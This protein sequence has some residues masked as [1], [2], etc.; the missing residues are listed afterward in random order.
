[1]W[2]FDDPFEVDLVTES[3]TNVLF[4]RTVDTLCAGVSPTTLFFDQSGPGCQPDPGVGLGTG[5]N[6]CTV[7]STG[8]QSQAIDISAI[9]AA[10]NG[11][12]VTLRFS[13]FDEGDSI[14]DSAVLLDQ[15]EVVKP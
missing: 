5:G 13:N 3:G 6:D 7:W 10:N 9:A 2:P 8:W 12:G 11:K 14:F 4:Y 1:V 15:V